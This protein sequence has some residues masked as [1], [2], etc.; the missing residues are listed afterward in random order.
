MIV[1]GMTSGERENENEDEGR[2]RRRKRPQTRPQAGVRVLCDITR[3]K[4]RRCD[5]LKR[6]DV[7]AGCLAYSHTNSS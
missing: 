4:L 3:D 7:S 5:A 2:G 1:P 6:S